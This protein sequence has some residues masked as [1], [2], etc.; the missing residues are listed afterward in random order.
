MTL[1]SLKYSSHMTREKEEAEKKHAAAE[2][3]AEERDQARYTTPA[4]DQGTQTLS[5]PTESLG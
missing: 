5:S 1:M 3:K 4:R 2:K